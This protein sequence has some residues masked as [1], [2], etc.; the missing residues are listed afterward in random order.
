MSRVPSVT[1]VREFEEHQTKA[2][3]LHKLVITVQDVLDT[4]GIPYKNLDADDME[5]SDVDISDQDY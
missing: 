3:F 1:L 2:E 5:D 4:M